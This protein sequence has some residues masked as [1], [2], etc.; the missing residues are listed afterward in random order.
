MAGKIDISELSTPPEKHELTT[1]RFFSEMGKDVTFIR[2]SNVPD[3]HRPDIKMNGIEW[4]IKSPSGKSRRSIEKRFSEAMEQ[5]ENIIFDLRRCG[6]SDEVSI[7]VLEKKFR[8]KHI[9]RLLIIT[10]A[11]KLLEYPEDCLDK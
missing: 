11:G 1:A 8:D 10:K 9:R 5:T 2:P 4:E 6:V 3:N 7:K